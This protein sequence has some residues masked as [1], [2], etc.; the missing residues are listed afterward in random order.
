MDAD[1]NHY[2][3]V[4]NQIHDY[5][6]ADKLNE[7]LPT[8]SSNDITSLV[9]LNARNLN[10]NLNLLVSNLMTV[11]HKFS[12]VAISETWTNEGNVDIPG[13]VKV[14]KSRGGFKAGV[15][16]YIDEDLLKNI[17]RRT[18]LEKIEHTSMENVFV[19]GLKHAYE[20]K[21]ILI[22]VV[23]RPPNTSVKT[24]LE[25]L[26]ELLNVISNEGRPC[27]LLGDFNVNLLNNTANNNSNDFVNVLLNFVF[28]PRIDRPTRIT[29]TTATL[30]DNIFTN[31]Y[32][33]LL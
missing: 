29:E 17:K 22:G 4:F 11:K 23:Y 32:M 15:A 8:H 1:H 25:N 16:L 5:Y 6:D 27:Y 18:D 19:Q 28:H 26:G 21:D 24:F 13:Y 9:H 12:V 7:I 10:K 2:N 3:Y 31:V 20:K 33:K 30:I 14:I